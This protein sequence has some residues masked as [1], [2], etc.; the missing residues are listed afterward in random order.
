MEL[1]GLH[2]NTRVAIAAIVLFLAFDMTALILNIWLSS[3]IEQQAIAINL[4]GRQRMLTQRM[5]K[6][7]LQIDYARLNALDPTPHLEELET[8]QK[9]F[10]DT[11]TGFARGHETLGGD[12]R[13]VRLEPVHGTKEQQ[14]VASAEALWRPYRTAIQDVLA[15]QPIAMPVTL[16][17]ALEYASKHNLELLDLMNQLTT[18]LE[19]QTQ[20]EAAQ[21]RW[22]QGAAF[23]LA[24]L[25]F[26]GAFAIYLH[27]LRLMSRS[28][29][30]LDTIIDKVQ[31]CVFVIGRDQRVMKANR[32]AEKLFGY[33]PGTLVGHH[34]DE[35]LLPVRE[36]E[37]HGLRADGS[38]FLAASEHNEVILDDASVSIITVSD[39][40]AQRQNEQHLSTLAYHDM[41]TKLPNR[42]LFDDRLRHAIVQAQ[43]EGTMLGIMFVD[44]DHF[45]PVNDTHGHEIGDR[46]LEAVAMRLRTQLRESDTVSRRGGDEFTILLTQVSGM[47]AC[48]RI[49]QS[50]LAQLAQPFHIEGI[51]LHIGASIG[52]S[53][54]PDHGR[55][56]QI[57][58]TRAD[59]AMYLAKQS[60]RNNWVLYQS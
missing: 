25:N 6:A 43:R 9:L 42:L 51:D 2:R 27:R 18:R 56:A 58:L 55:D 16:R 59:E 35:L 31:T 24:L 10:D 12:H 26:F 30:L 21:I 57:L 46:L 47:E 45:K 29:G 20:S 37:L 40:T 4:A 17:P 54:Y 36:D 33:L 7:L 14:L 23:G 13:T 1:S 60:G 41:L 22:F 34:L 15:A 38:T 3:R 39:I 44:L 49:A 5:T 28:H 8:T 19:Q 11:L 53:L 32:T 52:I 48:V 50:I